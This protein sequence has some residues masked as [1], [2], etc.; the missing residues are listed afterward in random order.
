MQ[1]NS[2]PTWRK[3]SRCG[4]AT[5]VEVAKVGEQYLVRD[6][7]TPGPTLTLDPH[8]WKAFAEGIADGEFRFN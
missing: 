6:S 8:Q 4:N 2:E 7:K 1:Q 5:C 3:S